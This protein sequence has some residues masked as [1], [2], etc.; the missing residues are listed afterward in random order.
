MRRSL[1]IEDRR[2]DFPARQLRQA[3]AKGPVAILHQAAGSEGAV[4]RHFWPTEA[5]RRLVQS[6]GKPECLGVVARVD[7]DKLPDLG[8]T[9]FPLIERGKPPAGGRGLTASGSFGPSIRIMKA[10][11]TASMISRSMG[12][13]ERSLD[14]DPV[15]GSAR[16]ALDAWPGPVCTCNCSGTRGSCTTMRPPKTLVTSSAPMGAVQHDAGELLSYLLGL[17]LNYVHRTSPRRALTLPYVV[18][19]LIATRLPGMRASCARSPGWR[20]QEATARQCR[21]TIF[22]GTVRGGSVVPAYGHSDGWKSGKIV[23]QALVGGRAPILYTAMPGPLG[24]AADRHPGSTIGAD[25]WPRRRFS[26]PTPL[27]S[28][29]YRK[30]EARARNRA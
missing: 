20:V 18:C 3:A 9:I 27:K 7:G 1:R 2:H 8:R 15:S 26:R 19:H 28:A 14:A 17:L 6:E 24:S 13:N 23:D 16:A 22:S 25:G 5:V 21:R 29:L 4:G 11:G 12:K 30:R 10:S